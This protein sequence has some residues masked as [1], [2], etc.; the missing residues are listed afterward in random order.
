MSDV[1]DMYQGIQAHKKRLRAKHGVNCPE[2]V[3]LLPK[4]NPTILMPQQRCRI[5]GYRDLRAELTD[6]QWS[7]A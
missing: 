7:D 5:H 2:C 4:A 3:R 1:A 6:E